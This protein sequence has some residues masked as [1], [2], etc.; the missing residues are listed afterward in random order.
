M[1]KKGLPTTDRQ[2]FFLRIERPT[3]RP[4]RRTRATWS[5]KISGSS[6]AST[7]K[8]SFVWRENGFAPVFRPMSYAPGVVGPPAT[9]NSKS[10]GCTW[11]LS[12]S[13]RPCRWSQPGWVFKN[14]ETRPQKNLVGNCHFNPSGVIRGFETVHTAQRCWSR[15]RHFHNSR[16]HFHSGPHIRVSHF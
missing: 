5:E 4:Q 11:A 13:S 12:D 8:F 16:Q 7:P 2:P 15:P 6:F 9:R 10:A 14:R 3:P 1:T